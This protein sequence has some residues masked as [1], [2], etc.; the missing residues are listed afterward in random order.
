VTCTQK[1]DGA[2]IVKNHHLPTIKNIPDELW[3]EIKK[4]LPKEKPTNTVG[5]PIVKYRKVL[6][7]ILYV[8]RTGCQWK[9]L[10]K[11][12]VQVQHAIDSSRNGIWQ[13]VKNPVAIIPAPPNVDIIRNPI[14]E[15]LAHALDTIP[16]NEPVSNDLFN[17][18]LDVLITYIFIDV[19][20]PKS[21][22]LV[23]V[24]IKPICASSG[25]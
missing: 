14:E 16:S 5:R 13:F 10:L 4:V 22:A 11:N 25:I 21:A 1:E 9:M 20:I 7:G 15:Q 2:K 3:D 24:I 6:E 17:L 23:V 18:T 8:L 12:T 19:T